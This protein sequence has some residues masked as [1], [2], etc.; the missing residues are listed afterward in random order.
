M[1]ARLQRT[2][3]LIISANTFTSPPPHKLTQIF[4]E[5]TFEAGAV[6]LYHTTHQTTSSYVTP[7]FKSLRLLSCRRLATATHHLAST[8]GLASRN[9]TRTRVSTSSSIRPCHT[10]AQRGTSQ[11]KAWPQCTGKTVQRAT[12]RR[13]RTHSKPH[14]HSVRERCQWEL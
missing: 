14:C 3:N 2:K 11:R 13:P 12:R 9:K 6:F 4:T 7:Q 5:A 8:T 10:E 1:E